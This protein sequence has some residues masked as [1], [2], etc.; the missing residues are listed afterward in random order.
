MYRQPSRD[1]RS[2]VSI[3]QHRR[4]GALTSGGPLAGRCRAAA[5]WVGHVSG[6]TGPDGSYCGQ[7]EVSQKVLARDGKEVSI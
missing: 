3:P 5:S 1:E 7:F 6:Q 2:V 4:A